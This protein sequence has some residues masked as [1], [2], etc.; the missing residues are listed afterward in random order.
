MT[1]DGVR[2]EAPARD[3]DVTVA[4]LA[5]PA[6]GAGEALVAVRAAGV[7]RSDLLN[8]RGLLPIVSW[9]RIPGRDFAGEVID[10]P[11][12]LRGRRV[13]G[14]GGHDLGFSRDGSHAQYAALP[15]AALAEIPDALSFEQAAACGLPFF[16]AGLALLRLAPPSAGATV[17]VTGAAGGVGS[18]AVEIARWRGATV[19]AAVRGAAEAAAVR[20]RGVAVVIDT[21]AQDLEAAVVAAVGADAVDVVVD[22]VGPPVFPAAAAVLGPD[23]RLVAMTAPPVAP[24]EVDLGRIYRMR[25]GLLGLSTVAYSAAE[26]AAVL[27]ELCGALADGSV[28]PPDVGARFPLARIAEAYAAV[29]AGTVLG[30]TLVLPDGARQG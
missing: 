28:A 11:P 16:T 9:P 23:G 4:P 18:A 29:D 27:R 10:G 30:R 15:V 25:Q 6:L 20:E 8:V 12:A 7:N 19:L 22:T 24:V 5:R 13:W 21:A 14:V 17:L 3:L 2:L 26:A 1:M